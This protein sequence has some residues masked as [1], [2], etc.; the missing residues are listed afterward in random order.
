MKINDILLEG[1]DNIQLKK[2]TD[3]TFMPNNTVKYSDLS[4]KSV[5]G[6]LKIN[7][8]INGEL[9]QTYSDCENHVG[10]IAATRLGKTT[11]YVIPTVLSFARQK[12]KKS[13]IISDPKG[14]IYRYT[15]E[16]LK[17]EGY[18]VRLINFRDHVHSECWNI[19]TPIYKKYHKVIE[20]EKEVEQGM[21]NKGNV[22]YVFRGRVF[23]SE[24]KLDKEIA[25][26]KAMEIEEVGNDI[27]N[28]AL[29]IVPTYDTK[30][31]YW[32]DSARDVFK[33][34]LWAMLEDS[35]RRRDVKYPI[36]EDTFS[37][38]SI[39]RIVS[40]FQDA[41]GMYYEDFGYFTLR[42]ADSRAYQLAKCSLIENGKPTRKCIM[43]CFIT[44]ISVFR[45]SAMRAI[46]SCNS[47]GIE[48][49]AEGPVALFIDYKD[50]IKAHYRIIS[51]IVHD[52]YTFLIGKA[53]E[54]GGKLEVPFYFILDEFGNFPPMTDFQTTISACAGRNIFFILIIQ[55]YA[56]L[57]S[58]Y[59]DKVAE[60]IRDNLNVH[61]FFGSNNPD[62]LEMFSRECGKTT[63]ISPMSAFNGRGE[64]IADYVL[65]TV[66][67]V[68]RS[69][70][71]HLEPGE[72]IVTEAN[73][74]YVI[75]SKM[76]RFYTCKEF[77]ENVCADEK[78]Y[79]CPLNPYDKKY[80]YEYEP[81][82]KG[83]I[84]LRRG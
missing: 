53:N 43:S 49:L 21:D 25:N 17:N 69:R 54:N 48:E 37:F 12:T 68:P 19:L 5:N 35:D 26:A 65:E 34:F 29:M 63:R 55:S 14:E 73:C 28:L 67:L 76:E 58:V 33:A 64:E 82:R 8:H 40:T 39:I 11:S 70:L 46:T 6:V 72:C 61:V 83:S 50:E 32:E 13:M 18:K 15:A 22:E 45:E 56:Q 51:L 60:I 10:V 71:S 1:Y 47:F 24:N 9:F 44:R 20:M 81:L 38:S 77:S 4:K 80:M 27:D 66:P 74:G 3:E 57:N 16:T 52:A 2:Y 30:D 78:K 79:K 23:K 7:R 84:F 41:D 36:T 31:P 59:G 75:F 62:T 42:G